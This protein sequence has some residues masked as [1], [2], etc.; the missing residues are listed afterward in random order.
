MSSLVLANIFIRGC[1][2]LGGLCA[3]LLPQLV[4]ATLGPDTRL[5]LLSVGLHELLQH[6]PRPYLDICAKTSC[7]EPLLASLFFADG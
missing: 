1:S 4:H 2:A 5:L 6:F 7:R 3:P